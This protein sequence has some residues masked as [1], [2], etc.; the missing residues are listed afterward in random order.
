[1]TLLNDRK[2]S[3]ILRASV[4]EN[5]EGAG[6]RG[7]KVRQSVG[8]EVSLEQLNQIGG[9]CAPTETSDSAPF[10][11]N[12]PYSSSCFTDVRPAWVKLCQGVN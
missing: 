3:R 1:M 8:I 12:Y 11:P 7:L 6:E 9:G 10:P 2:S 5:S 4:K